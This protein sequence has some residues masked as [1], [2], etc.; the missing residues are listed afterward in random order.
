MSV[1][2]LFRG[3]VEEQRRELERMNRIDPG[4]TVMILSIAVMCCLILAL[5]HVPGLRPT[6]QVLLCDGEGGHWS[7]ATQVCM[8]SESP[9]AG[10]AS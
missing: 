4:W 1:S 8:K 3:T 7:S 9:V 5:V 6:E 2:A 10:L